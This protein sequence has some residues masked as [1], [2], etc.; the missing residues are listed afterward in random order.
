MAHIHEMSSASSAK[1]STLG[2]GIRTPLVINH[3]ADIYYEV[4]CPVVASVVELPITEKSGDEN[5]N[6]WKFLIGNV[7]NE[8]IVYVAFAS[9]IN[10]ELDASIVLTYTKTTYLYPNKTLDD[11]GYCIQ[12]K[13]DKMKS[14]EPYKIGSITF[15]RD[16]N[17]TIKFHAKIITTETTTNNLTLLPLINNLSSMLGN[18]MFSDFTIKVKI[19]NDEVNI[20]VHK[21]IL[22]SRSEFFRGLFS[23]G[24]KEQQEGSLT[25][26]DISPNTISN[27]LRFIYTSTIIVPTTLEE[28][29]ELTI[30]SHQYLLSSLKDLCSKYLCDFVSVKTARTILHLNHKYGLSDELREMCK[31]TITNNIEEYANYEEQQYE[32]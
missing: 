21:I 9:P 5:R 20:P 18:S 32:P 3:V 23:N 7:R 30:A 22:A 12:I 1:L 17:V 26:K 16:S 27:I 14:E 25:I 28:M 8:N 4:K 6:S 15:P 2:V 31:K 24:M 10:K 11:E 29:I 19:E 13:K